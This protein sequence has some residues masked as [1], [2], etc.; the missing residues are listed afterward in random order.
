MNWCCLKIYR[1][2]GFVYHFWLAFIRPLGNAA[3][4]I[5]STMWLILSIHLFFL[6][7]FYSL[8]LLFI[9]FFST[10]CTSTYWSASGLQRSCHTCA[11]VSIVGGNTRKVKPLWICETLQSAQ[12]C[13]LREAPLHERS[14]GCA[15][16]MQ[17]LEQGFRIQGY[18]CACASRCPR[19]WF[20]IRRARFLAI[21]RGDV[22]RSFALQGRYANCPDFADS[23]LRCYSRESANRVHK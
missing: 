14:A 12:R 5:L 21:R 18:F 19:P 9:F 2:L 3:F 1:R 15:H 17:H 13:C 6:S 22:G 11:S 10:S 8:F 7:S 16:K 4:W 20:V 23:R